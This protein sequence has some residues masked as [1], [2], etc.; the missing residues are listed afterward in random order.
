MAGKG[1]AQHVRVHRRGHVGL[2]AAA[3]QALPDRLRRQARAVA[4]L[5]QG[6]G[7]GGRRCLPYV[8]PEHGAI[9]AAMVLDSLGAGVGGFGVRG[10][11]LWASVRLREVAVLHTALA[12]RL[13]SL[14]EKTEAL[15]MSYDT[16]RRNP[17]NQLRQV[18]AAL[19]ELTIPPDSPKRP[20]GFVTPED[21]PKGSKA[22]RGKKT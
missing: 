14:E 22:T 5:K 9:M 12:E 15:A 13:S 17:R 1:V 18:F 19:R 4:P 10:A 20:I 8:F 21:K 7:R 6:G 2:Q 16:F 11:R 3:L